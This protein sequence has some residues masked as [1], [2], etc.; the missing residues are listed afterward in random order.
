MG[1]AESWI[2]V[3]GLTRE[4]FLNRLD[5][6]ETE[7]RHDYRDCGFSKHDP[8]GG[9]ATLPNGRQLYVST[10]SHLATPEVAAR[11]SV[12]A[13]LIMG[14]LEEHV[15]VSEAYSFTDGKM[16]WMILHNRES[17]ERKNAPEVETQGDLPNS[18][19]GA[20][21]EA[22]RVGEYT[23]LPLAVAAAVG[24]W[25]PDEIPDGFDGIFTLLE[26]KSD[27]DRRRERESRK[28][29]RKAKG[30]FFSRLFGGN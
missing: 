5:L 24:G 10:Y 21:A 29:E 23:G 27:A 2:S 15:D 19:R 16:D 13:Q 8:D 1:I 11:V 14:S 9:V 3:A 4:E 30:G 17:Q 28:A 12:G 7:Y 25:R 18:F 20:L 22:D 26:P 6:A